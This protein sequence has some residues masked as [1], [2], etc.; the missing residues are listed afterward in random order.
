MLEPAVIGIDVETSSTV[1]LTARGAD[2]YIRDP[3]TRCLMVGFHRVGQSGK[4]FLWLE[5]DPVPEAIVDHVASGGQFSGWNVI[6][7]DRG[8]YARILVGHHG[9]PAVSDDVWRDS[10]HLAAHA[11]RPRSLDGCAA[12]LGLTFT[13]S[14]KDTHRIRRITDA[15]K[16]PIPAPLGKILR[17]PEQFGPKLV[18]DMTWLAYRC[19]QDVELEEAVLLK[20]PPWPDMEPWLHMPAID[21]RINDRGVLVDVELVR[22]LTKAAAYESE[23]LNVEI[24]DL[25]RGLVPKHSR[26]GAL[27]EWLVRE[28]VDLPLKTDPT[29]E[30]DEDEEDQPDGSGFKKPRET[31]G[32]K[33]R[34]RKSDIADLMARDDVPDHC[35]EALAIRAEA[36][37]ASVAKLRRMLAMVGPD[38]RLRNV[39]K[40]GGAQQTLRWSGVD[41]QVHNLV[42]DTFANP[43]EVAEVNNLDPKKDRALVLHLCDVALRTG[44]EVGRTGDEEFMRQMFTRVRKD[45]QGRE[46]T[47][48]VIGWISRMLRRTLCAGSGRL[49][50]NGDF[51]QI[52]ARIPMWLAGQEDKVAAYNRGEDMYRRQAAPFFGLMPEQ[53]SKTQ[54]QIGKVQTLFCGFGGGVNA[55]VPMAMNYGIRISREEALPAVQSFRNDNPM[56]TSFWYNNLMAARYALMYPG[57]EVWTPPKGLVSWFTQDDCL[58]CRLPSGRCL[59]YWSPRLEVGKWPDGTVKD[60]PDITVLFV[61]GRAVFRRTLW[62][63]LSMENITQAIAADLLANGLAAADREGLSVPIHVHDSIAAEEHED[64]TEDLLPLFKQCMLDVP[65]WATG[66]PIAVEADISARFG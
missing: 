54:R 29:E 23:R 63:G 25:T 55:F 27:K 8:I 7:F 61:K 18:E 35:R 49:L 32:G 37:K 36:A 53:L 65:A 42:R 22:G 26:V 15:A 24:N 19:V 6:G 20:L 57:Q 1:N 51:A 40:L 59:R 9:W 66:L 3:S 48:G 17:S 50:L 28:G 4:P 46:Y 58:L 39:L 5:G 47:E 62:H 44:I 21:R 38:G 64:H 14:L 56:L 16:T 43:D 12:S 2:A 34:L 13:A 60:V 52:E 30:D 41:V 31:V 45:A 33:W 10:M 11:N